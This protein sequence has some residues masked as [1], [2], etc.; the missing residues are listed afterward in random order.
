V[1][2][3]CIAADEVTV[4]DATQQLQSILETEQLD[5]LLFRGHTPPENNLPR[6]F[7]GQVLAQA[8]NSAI[9]TVPEDRLMH[10]MH[11]Y[12]LRP[13]DVNHPI[14][15]EVDPIRDGG[16]FTTRRVVAKQHGKAIFNTSLSFKVPEEG[17]QHSNPM[18]DVPQPE[19]LVNDAE[20]LKALLAKT[21]G[22]K[23]PPIRADAF[24]CF[25][26]RTVGDLPLTLER[27]HPPTQGFWFKPKATLDAPF[28]MH[29]AFLAYASDFRLMM[30]ALLPHGMKDNFKN[31]I[32]ASLDH[33]LW[34]HNPFDINDWL[35][36]H[37]DGPVASS[38]CG[39]NF[40]HFYTRDGKI[41][42]SSSQEGLMRLKASS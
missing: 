31:L 5:S 36:Y 6:V 11:A 17:L 2:V 38:G 26:M 20:R 39:L 22:T 27:G 13:G 29:Q 15:F 19:E 41:V 35:Y 24:Q 16:S 3:T 18:P 10:S 25:D 4:T 32:A 33:S 9:Q 1:F 42:A 8:L 37:M 23:K 34:I 14:L 12:F 21:P 7:G 28:T 30:T 40:G